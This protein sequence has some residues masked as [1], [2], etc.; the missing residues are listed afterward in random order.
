LRHGERC[1]PLALWF[2]LVSSTAQ[3]RTDRSWPPYMSST[4]GQPGHPGTP[5]ARA[6]GQSAPPAIVR[7]Q[8]LRG[9]QGVGGPIGSSWRALLACL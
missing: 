2:A 5:I 6:G 3:D 1:S 9:Y 4:S 8:I 7:S